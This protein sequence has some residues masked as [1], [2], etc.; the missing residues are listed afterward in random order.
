M[1]N[2]N[3]D[4]NPIHDWELVQKELVKTEEQLKAIQSQLVDLI[5]ELRLPDE[6]N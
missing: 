3:P 4:K 1:S 5:H 2:P 6:E